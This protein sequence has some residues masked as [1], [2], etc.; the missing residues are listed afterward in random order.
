MGFQL[1]SVLLDTVL[2][3]R[4]RGLYWE[5][6]LGPGTVL[7]EDSRGMAYLAELIANP[8][9]EIPAAD[10]A[11]GPVR[12][13]NPPATA[14]PVLDDV[15]RDAY[16]RRLTELDAAIEESD[17]RND[18]ARA[19]R[20]REERAW[21]IEELTAAA[22]LA[23]RPRRFADEAE[24]ARISVGKAIRRALTRVAAADEV[25]GGH[26]RHTVRTGLRCTYLPAVSRGRRL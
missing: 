15:A 19:E 3:C 25:I 12:A 11:A 1:D 6:R 23:G 4:R 20:A 18:L 21:L 17:A 5:L 10:L 2:T 26:L 9:Y 13:V 22:G 16:R 24:R 7:L 8:G 14:Q